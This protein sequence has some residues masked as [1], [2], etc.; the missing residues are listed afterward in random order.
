MIADVGGAL[1]EADGFFD[2]ADTLEFGFEADEGVGGGE[3]GVAAG[4]EEVLAVD[5]FEAAE[6]GRAGGE[7]G[8][9]EF[10]ALTDGL[11]GGLDGGGGD[12]FSAEHG[13]GV[14]GKFVEAG[15]GEGDAEVLA[16]DVFEL[17]GFVEDDGGGFG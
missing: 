9:E 13:V 4:F 8:E 10:G 15:V 16:G 3:V 17:V 11:G 14:A 12:A 7:G 6:V 1:A 2:V 5:E